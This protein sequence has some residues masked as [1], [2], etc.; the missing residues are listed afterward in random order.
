MR[1]SFYQPTL[2]YNRITLSVGDILGELKCDLDLEAELIRGCETLGEGDPLKTQL[3]KFLE[4]VSL[5]KNKSPSDQ[6]NLTSPNFNHLVLAEPRTPGG[7]K[8]TTTTNAK[9]KE[10]RSLLKTYESRIRELERL[11]QEKF[12]ETHGATRE[13]RLQQAPENNTNANSKEMTGETEISK[14]R[15]KLQARIASHEFD[16]DDTVLLLPTVRKGIWSL[17]STDHSNYYLHP[18]SLKTLDRDANSDWILGRIQSIEKKVSTGKV[19]C[20]T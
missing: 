17:F 2:R 13:S 5:L 7:E 20:E 12:Q 16:V 9:E 19:L 18:T 14:L 8:G 1:C 6:L 10:D 3:M 15:D 11:L 4:T